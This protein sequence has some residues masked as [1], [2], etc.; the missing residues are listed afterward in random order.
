MTVKQILDRVYREYEKDGDYLSF[1]DSDMQLWFDYLKD[2]LREWVK[3]F[4]HLKEVY[5]KLADATDGSKTT[6]ANQDTYNAPS[7]FIRPLSFI[8]V[9]DE[10]YHYLPHEKM[11]YEKEYNPNNKWFSVIGYEGA[12]KI[13]IYPTPTT[14]GTTISYDYMATITNPSGESSVV[15]ISRPDFC[16]YYILY[17]LYAD[18]QSNKDLAIKYEQ[19][20]LDEIRLEKIE[21]ARRPYG[22]RGKT[23][24]VYGFALGE[25]DTGMEI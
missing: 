12:Y 9:G 13:V 10:I 17:Q 7:N 14:T 25:K 8:K 19:K 5:A 18:D 22:Q 24:D 16:V 4:P 3:Y 6:V 1:T 21:Q 20:M 15:A 2:S 23:Q 11:L